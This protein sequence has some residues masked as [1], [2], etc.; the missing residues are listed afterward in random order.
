MDVLFLQAESVLSA[1]LTVDTE[2]RDTGFT[3]VIFYFPFLFVSP[4]LW[5]K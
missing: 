3:S 4:K 2:F 5:L 1:D